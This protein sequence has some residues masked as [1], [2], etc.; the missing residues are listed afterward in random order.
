M[1]RECFSNEYIATR[2]SF[3]GMM[4]L[5]VQMNRALEIVRERISPGFAYEDIHTRDIIVEPLSSLT[6]IDYD[7]IVVEDS[8]VPRVFKF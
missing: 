6:I 4:S 8:A 1:F 3:F 2:P 7:G 5:F